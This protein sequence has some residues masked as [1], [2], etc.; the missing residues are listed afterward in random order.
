MSPAQNKDISIPEYS[1]Q[2]DE[3]ISVG[4]R[5]LYG[6]RNSTEVIL[7]SPKNIT[8]NELDQIQSN[9]KS[10]GN[11]KF[12]LDLTLESHHVP[13]NTQILSSAGEV[14][15][16]RAFVSA[17]VHKI[18]FISEETDIKLNLASK[19][20][21]Y[22]TDIALKHE[23]ETSPSCQSHDTNFFFSLLIYCWLVIAKSRS[24]Y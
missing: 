15:S 8:N 24:R 4:V 13:L 18:D 23:P 2:S 1:K 7:E 22:H 9:L 21:N 3:K 20:Q 16:Q 5:D 6:L 12:R 19:S 11:N 17:G 10:L 14:L